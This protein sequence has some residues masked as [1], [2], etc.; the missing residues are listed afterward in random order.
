MQ[1]GRLAWINFCLFQSNCGLVFSPSVFKSL[2]VISK[3]N[4]FKFQLQ[5]STSI[6]NSKSLDC[7]SAPLALSITTAVSEL[8]W[9]QPCRTPGRPQPGRAPEPAAASRWPPRS[10]WPT[11]IRWTQR[12]PCPPAR[13]GTAGTPSRTCW[14]ASS[15]RTSWPRRRSRGT[16]PRRPVPSSRPSWLLGEGPLALRG[17]DAT[18]RAPP[19]KVFVAANHTDFGVA[20]IERRWRRRSCPTNLPWTWWPF[21]FSSPS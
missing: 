2:Q 15:P 3:T 12:A 7:S 17:E 5:F 10:R 1:G 16:S 8:T 4:W 6:F 11:R 20:E 18:R 14:A 21:V 9:S 13:P 19:L